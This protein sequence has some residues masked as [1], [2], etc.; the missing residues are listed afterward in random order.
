MDEN[1]SIYILGCISPGMQLLKSEVQT[2]GPHG[3]TPRIY[4][5]GK[6]RE[7]MSRIIT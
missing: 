5:L 1:L 7:G 3:A 6:A 2:P 4:I